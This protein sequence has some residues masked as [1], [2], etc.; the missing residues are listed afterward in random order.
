MTVSTPN[1]PANRSQQREQMRERIL[2]AATQAFAWRGF[3][4]ASLDYIASLAQVQKT[5]V[6][7]HFKTKDALWKQVVT[8]LWQSRD[9]ELPHYTPNTPATD[10]SGASQLLA[11]YR[12]L[13]R[14]SREQPA[15]LQIMFHEAAQPGPRL[16]WL[17][18]HYLRQ[19]IES[20]LAFV[21]M[22][23]RQSD[24]PAVNDLDLLL[25]ISSAL[26][27]PLL[28]AN[29]THQVT[30][31]NLSEPDRLEHYLDSFQRILNAASQKT[32]QS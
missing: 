23:Q 13:A 11:V 18:D 7:Y 4:G 20:G 15:W 10:N 8:R 26:T 24:L 17:I 6:Q 14:F 30:G 9:R 3:D 32:P 28:V 19:D 21:Q 12:A 1:P 2:Q 22:A 25:L 5:L 16:E 31:D 27:Y 29:L